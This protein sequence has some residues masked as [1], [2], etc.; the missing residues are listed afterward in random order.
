MYQ[1]GGDPWLAK[2]V[3]DVL[4]KGKINSRDRVQGGSSLTPSSTHRRRSD[5]SHL[6]NGENSCS[7]GPAESLAMPD[8]DVVN[9]RE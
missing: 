3:F 4:G 1:S 7:I 2:S 5:V 9:S 8:C 6:F